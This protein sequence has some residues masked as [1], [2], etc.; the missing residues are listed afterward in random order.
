MSGFSEDIAFGRIVSTTA[1]GDI[2][3]K[4][5]TGRGVRVGFVLV[6]WLLRAANS[7]IRKLPGQPVG[8]RKNRREARRHRGPCA[9][10]ALLIQQAQQQPGI[11]KAGIKAAFCAAG[12]VQSD[13]R[14]HEPEQGGGRGKAFRKNFECRF[15]VR[16]RQ[17]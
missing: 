2:V 12:P 4:P 8:D 14:R 10:L 6:P 1:F 5:C 13:P 17:R 3:R 7:R 11:V 9:P 16:F 15:H